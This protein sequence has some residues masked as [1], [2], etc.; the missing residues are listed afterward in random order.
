MKRL[1]EQSRYLLL[2][3][4]ATSF[5]AFLSVVVWGLY[6]T[7]SVI[8]DI[9]NGSIKGPMVTVSLLEL[10]DTYLVTAVLYI[11]RWQ[12]TNSLSGT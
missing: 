5:V 4:V 6:K 10:L 12:S 8:L 1:L 9:A 7:G 11:L 3:V 2:L